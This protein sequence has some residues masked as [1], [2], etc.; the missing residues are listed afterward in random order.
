MFDILPSRSG[1]ILVCGHRGHSI[2]GHENTR[3]ALQRARELGASLC[4][5]D[6]RMTRDGRL[7]VYH[8]DI[9]DN[10]ST[11]T[12]LISQMN[13]AG[14]A[15][16]QTKNRNGLSV[17][18]QP[19][20]PFEDILAYCRNLG[21]GLIVEI[22]DKFEGTAH[23]EQV[24]TLL[25][26]TDMFERVLIS[27]FDYVVLRDIKRIAPGIRTMGINYHRL[28][29]PAS[30]AS[31]AAMDVM[32]T[33]Y[34]QF[35]PDIAESLHAAGVSVSHYV[36]PPQHFAL[37]RSYGFDYLEVLQSHM[38][39]GLIDMLVCD[40]VAWIVAFTK[41]CGLSPAQLHFTE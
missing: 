28:V 15:R 24:V 27:S 37:R 11:G 5:I 26:E 39:A 40:D 2:D 14:I 17:G 16:L 29:D 19:I 18:E 25:K 35:M 32:N 8:D 7:I 12:G 23:L 20:E 10:A 38:R 36:P 4:E 41:A 30:A 22:K 33:D 34:P 3:P 1:R 31:S 13:Y 21:L 6:L 9:L